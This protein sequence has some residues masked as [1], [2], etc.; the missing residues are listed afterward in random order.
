MVA[1]ITSFILVPNVPVVT[2]SSLGYQSNQNLF[3]D[4][5]FHLIRF[6]TPHTHS[7]VKLSPLKLPSNSSQTFVMKNDNYS[8]TSGNMVADH[9]QNKPQ[10]LNKFTQMSSVTLHSKTSSQM[11]TTQATYLFG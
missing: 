6:S 11:Q 5:T 9:V 7:I 1:V 3:H 8:Q 4:V 10:F 2:Q